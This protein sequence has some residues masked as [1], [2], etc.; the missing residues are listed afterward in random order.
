MKQIC[1]SRKIS[2]EGDEDAYVPAI[3]FSEFPAGEYCVQ[4]DP[5]NP[6]KP[7]YFL[8]DG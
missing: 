4:D 3:P 6:G 5:D 2:Q 8:V 1:G 7:A